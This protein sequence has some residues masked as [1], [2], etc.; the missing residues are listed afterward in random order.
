M[1]AIMTPIRPNF[2]KAAAATILS[3]AAADLIGQYITQEDLCITVH[4]GSRKSCRQSPNTGIDTLLSVESVIGTEF[5][6]TYTAAADTDPVYGSAVAFGAAGAANV[7]SNGTFNEF[8]GGGGDDTII[9][10][11]NTRVAFYNATDGVAVTLIRAGPAPRSAPRRVIW[12]TLEPIRLL[13]AFCACVARS[14][15]TLSPA[16]AATTSRGPGRQ[17]CSQR[18]GWQ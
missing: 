18:Q 9:G 14:L 1:A 8:E 7:G 11:G 17:R 2:S 10:N 16:T 6:D 12:L 4:L 15:A 13:A 3:T 5:A